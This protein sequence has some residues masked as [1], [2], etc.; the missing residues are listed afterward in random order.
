MHSNHSSGERALLVIDSCVYVGIVLYQCVCVC[1]CVCDL[2]RKAWWQTCGYTSMCLPALDSEGEDEDEEE[3][4][5]DED[6]ASTC[7]TD[8]EHMAIRYVRGHLRTPHY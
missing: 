6:A 8:S 7:S 3:D 5:G 2:S 1:V 4:D